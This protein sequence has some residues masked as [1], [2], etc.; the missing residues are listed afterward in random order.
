MAAFLS[1]IAWQRRWT[2]SWPRLFVGYFVVWCTGRLAYDGL[3][4]TPR[5]FLG[6]YAYVALIAGTVLLLYYDRRSKAS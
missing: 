6:D 2:L 3:E 5:S 1:V 4:M